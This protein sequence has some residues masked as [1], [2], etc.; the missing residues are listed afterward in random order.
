MSADGRHGLTIIAFIGSVFSPYY[1][2]AR[3][4]GRGDPEN[5]VCMNVA[6]YGAPR[7]WAM[8]ERGV[9]SLTRDAGRITIGASAM[10]W[11]GEALTI[12]L[13]E[14]TV[15]IPSRLRGTVVVRPHAVSTRRF[16][17]DAAGRHRWQPIGPLS[18]VTVDL[19]SP[20]L[21]WR[22][23]GYLDTNDGD[24]PLEDAFRS[25]TWTRFDMGRHARIFYDV[26]ARDGTPHALSLE[27]RDGR[28]VTAPA[29]AFQ[30]LAT[31]AWGIRRA[32]PCEAGGRACLVESLENAP[33][34]ARA[35]VRSRIDGSDVTGVHESLSLRRLTSPVVRLMLPFKMF[36]RTVGAKTR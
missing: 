2:F 27:V 19:Q 7:R 31:T 29:L 26:V 18:D 20:S 33:F 23:T 5:H 4:R 36:R 22:G 6:L 11:D 17:L 8:T 14:T 9:G 13:D 1:A 16:D 3:G 25:W 10:A 28:V 21:T 15:P 30:E 35:A 24:E 34:Y 12:T 32:V